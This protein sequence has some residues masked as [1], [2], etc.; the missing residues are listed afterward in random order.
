MICD[1]RKPRVMVASMALHRV[2][3]CKRY[4]YILLSAGSS[5]ASDRMAH[6][7]LLFLPACVSCKCAAWPCRNFH[8]LKYLD[9]LAEAITK[10]GGRIFEETR[11][12]EM[13]GLEVRARAAPLAW[14]DCNQPV[15]RCCWPGPSSQVYCVRQWRAW[16]PV[17]CTLKRTYVCIRP[18]CEGRKPATAS[19]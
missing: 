15:V 13:K 4:S 6:L 8:A 7:Q 16:H 18:D 3:I 19:C 10:H 14:C 5:A 11:V 12:R 17:L 1:L 9:G 2:C